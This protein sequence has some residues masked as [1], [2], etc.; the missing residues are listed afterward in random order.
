MIQDL[1]SHT[2]Y[3][4]CGK[5][6]PETLINAAIDGGIEVLG[7][8]DHNYGIGFA[9]KELYRSEFDISNENY[10]RTLI[11]YFDHM[12]L[13]KEKYADKINIKRGIEIATTLKFPRMLLPENMPIFYFDYALIEHVGDPERSLVGRDLFGYVKKLGCPS[14]IA[15][16]DIFGYIATLGKEPLAF[17]KQM[18]ELGM[19]WEL[20][21]NFDSIHNYTE[22][23]YVK[24]F[25]ESERE[26]E[27]V[28]ESGIR[29]SIGFDSHKADEYNAERIKTACAKVESLGISLVEV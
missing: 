20:N 10:E 7:I 8:C 19:F 3:S 6:K 28:R 13:L 29:L 23:A 22:H 18:A 21:V 9:R 14:G 12:T 2:Y 5:D 17:L 27:L 24:R 11:R 1:H 26:Q 16:T 25:F 4:F 15:H